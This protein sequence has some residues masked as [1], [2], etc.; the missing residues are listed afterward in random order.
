VDAADIR[1]SLVGWL[2]YARFAD[3]YNFRRRLFAGFRLRR[4]AAG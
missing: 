2:G 4:G 3:T 1:R